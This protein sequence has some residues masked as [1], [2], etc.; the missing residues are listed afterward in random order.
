MFAAPNLAAR[1]SGFL[2][3]IF[4]TDQQTGARPQRRHS[5]R[6]VN[7]RH[8]NCLGK[9]DYRCDVDTACGVPKYVHRGPMAGRQESFYLL[10]L[11]SLKILLCFSLALL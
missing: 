5:I 8:S 6:D 9:I 4:G 1:R 7:D 11:E 10:P 2:E 3:F